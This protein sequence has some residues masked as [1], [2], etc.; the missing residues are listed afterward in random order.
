[1][2]FFE[3]GQ[4]IGKADVGPIASFAMFA[5]YATGSVITTLFELAY[6]P[7]L[8]SSVVPSELLWVRQVPPIWLNVSLT[9]M[10][11]I[12]WLA[13]LHVP[14]R[15]RLTVLLPRRIRR[16]LRRLRGPVVIWDGLFPPIPISPVTVG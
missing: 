8:P 13:Y 1:M 12:W 6:P 2:H 3:M 16:V 4:T 9:A 7:G 14:T 5:S 15:H 10:L 11:V